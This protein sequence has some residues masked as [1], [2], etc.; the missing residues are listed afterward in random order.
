MKELKN[1]SSGAYNSNTP[2]D[3]KSLKLQDLERTTS[4]IYSNSE[5][6]KLKG[7]NQ[8]LRKKVDILEKELQMHQG[9]GY[10][11]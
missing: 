6:D 1:N 10:K 2:Y 9:K 7:E 11:Q 3:E 8:G 4:Q 5:L